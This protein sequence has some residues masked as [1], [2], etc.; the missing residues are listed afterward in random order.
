MAAVAKVGAHLLGDFPLAVGAILAP[1]GV[2]VARRRR[3]VAMLVLFI[4]VHL[5]LTS[6]A[7][8]GGPRF[9][10]PIDVFLFVLAASVLAGGWHKPT[11]WVMG[12]GLG[13]SM[14][15]ASI[16]LSSWPES[17]S[18]R[19]DYGVAAWASSAEG[20]LAT[21]T[22]DTGFNVKSPTGLAE[23]RVWKLEATPADTRL[24]VWVDGVQVD[25][26]TLGSEEPRLRYLT[27]RQRG[28]F[29]ELRP[30]HATGDPPVFGIEA[31]DHRAGAG[32]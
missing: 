25:R 17:L 24:D 3:V 26:I 12:I 9:R 1:L 2:A 5:G 22:G 31:F 10:E 21:A 20:R 15:M 30:V 19:A 7:G 4:A 29:V 16:V 8:S 28:T 27:S 11:R 14:L 32:R 23:F 6:L 13:G 18:S